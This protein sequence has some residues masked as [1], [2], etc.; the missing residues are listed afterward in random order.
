MARLN[1]EFEGDLRI[2]FNLAPPLTARRDPDTGLPV[3]RE[4]GSWIRGVFEVLRSLKGLRGTVFDIF[5][6]TA[7]RRLERQLIVDYEELT[8]KLIDGLTPENHPVTIELAELAWE[9]RGFGHVK[10]GTVENVKRR[11]QELLVEFHQSST[12]VGTAQAGAS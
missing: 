4:Y 10:E 11:E 1:E 8:R 9:I 5:G 7:E 3:K 6:H 12:T 2:K